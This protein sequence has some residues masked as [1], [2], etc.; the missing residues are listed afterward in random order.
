MH[1]QNSD[2]WRGLR[3]NLLLGSLSGH[4]ALT[5]APFLTRV[6]L[7]SGQRL[8]GRGAEDE[9]VYFP[10]TAVA[11]V[12]FPSLDRTGLGVGV[13]G[14]EGVLGWSKLVGGEH[15]QQEGLVHLDGGTAL[16]IDCAKLITLCR[17]NA[18][19]L[20]ALLRF[21]YLLSLQLAGT[22]VSNLR[23]TPEGRLCRW[24]LMF[25]DRRV[26]DELII[27]HD[28]LGRLLGVR[29]ATVTDTLHILEG[30]QLVRCTRGRIIVRDR[31]GLEACAGVAYGAAEGAYSATI[32]RFSKSR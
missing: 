11:C 7:E 15:F 30:E 4:D 5:V 22:L 21:S 24:I 6:T 9:P 29:R 2:P 26:G 28:A 23:D 10:E 12:S 1:G 3:G 25:H 20:H 14:Y 16:A 8:L 13:V 18:G 32:A 17:S 31:I 27:T 19:L